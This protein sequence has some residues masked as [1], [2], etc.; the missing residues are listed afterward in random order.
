MSVPSSEEVNCAVPEKESKKRGGHEGHAHGLGD[1]HRG[2][3]SFGHHRVYRTGQSSDQGAHAG[4]GSI[5]E[6]QKNEYV[7]QSRRESMEKHVGG[8]DRR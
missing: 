4:P 7:A 2:S 3:H 5:S 6:Q 1:P 8:L